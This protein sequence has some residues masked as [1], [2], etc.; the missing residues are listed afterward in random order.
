MW[1]EQKSEHS[2]PKIKWAAVEQ[3]VGIAEYGGAGAEHRIG[4]H[5][6]EAEQCEGCNCHSKY[7]PSSQ[8][9]AALSHRDRRYLSHWL[10]PSLCIWGANSAL[11]NVHVLVINKCRAREDPGMPIAN[12]GPLTVNSSGSLHS[13]HS[14][15][16][17]NAPITGTKLKITPSI[18]RSIRVRQNNVCY[19]TYG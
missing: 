5:G 9:T 4:H 14:I 17:S 3:W 19:R 8:L 11:Q 15:P 1:M 6:V 16:V 2:G 12:A 13:P 7:A 18:P 10:C